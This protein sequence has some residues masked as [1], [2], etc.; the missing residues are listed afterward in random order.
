MQ[1]ILR[2]HILYFCYFASVITLREYYQLFCCIFYN[3]HHLHLFI[4]EGITLEILQL[5]EIYLQL[6]SIKGIALTV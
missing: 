6:Q 4:D 2:E 3:R 5:D 1:L